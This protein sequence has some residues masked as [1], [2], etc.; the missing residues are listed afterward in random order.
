M[1]HYRN[2][3]HNTKA[4]KL[5]RIIWFGYAFIRFRYCRLI[6]RFEWRFVSEIYRLTVEWAWIE[7]TT[8]IYCHFQ[9]KFY[10]KIVVDDTITQLASKIPLGKE[11]HTRCVSMYDICLS[12]R[13]PCASK[14]F[15]IVMQLLYPTQM[16]FLFTKQMFMI[17]L[18]HSIY[19]ICG[20]VQKSKAIGSWI[21]DRILSEQNGI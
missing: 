15:R 18:K 8:H 21:N 3:I 7:F 13:I 17:H 1:N 20:W 2:S 5:C 4:Y 6:A 12:T 11:Y 19:K 10:W 9:L 14:F 16:F